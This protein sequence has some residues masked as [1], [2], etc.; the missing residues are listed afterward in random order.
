MGRAL[1]GVALGA[2]ITAP[3]HAAGFSI[4]EQG[5]KAMG[6]AGAFTAQADDPSLLFHNVGG[7]GFVEEQEFS[8]GFTWI[9]SLEAEFEGANPFPGEGYRAEQEL[10]SEVPPHVYYV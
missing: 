7:L 3:L 5:T 6:M 4:F 9:H 2:L 8:A 10:L 1:Y